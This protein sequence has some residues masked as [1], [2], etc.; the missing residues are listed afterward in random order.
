M[1]VTNVKMRQ[2]YLSS[3]KTEPLNI[4]RLSFFTCDRQLRDPS[5]YLCSWRQTLKAKSVKCRRSQP[6]ALP[7]GHH[8]VAAPFSLSMNLYCS[9]ILQ[10]AFV[11]EEQWPTLDAKSIKYQRALRSVSYHSRTPIS[12]LYQSNNHPKKTKET[13]TT[14]QR[15]QSD[16][17]IYSYPQWQ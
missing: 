14:K 13:T 16:R 1:Y 12:L 10:P 9:E 17:N 2:Q 6:T 3:P 4:W 7:I 15:H 8:S 11:L 5:T